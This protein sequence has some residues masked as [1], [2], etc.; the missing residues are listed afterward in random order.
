MVKSWLVKLLKTSPLLM[1]MENL[2]PYFKKKARRELHRSQIK[3]DNPQ[4]S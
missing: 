4:S 3:E 2:L 1:K